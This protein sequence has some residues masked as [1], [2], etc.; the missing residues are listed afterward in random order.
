MRLTA[1]LLITS[2]AITLSV[3]QAAAAL[4]PEVKAELT[5]MSRELRSVTSLLRKKEIAEAKAIVTKTEERLKELNIAKDERDRSLSALKTALQRAKTAIPVSFESGVAPIIKDKCMR[6]HGEDQQSAGLRLDSYAAMGRGGR[7]GPLLIPRNPQRSLILAR[8]MADGQARMPRGGQKLSDEEISIIGRWIAGGAAFDGEDVQA[9]IGASTMEKKPPKPK[10]KVVMA[11]GSET[12]SFRDDV[13]PTLVNVC[14]RC[15]GDNNPRG[16]FRMTTFEQLLSGGDTGNTIVPGDPDGSYIVDLVLRQDPI[17]MPAGNQTQIKRSQAQAIEKWIREGAHFDGTDPKGTL[18]SLVPTAEELASAKLA[19]MSDKEFSDRRLEQAASLWKRVSPRENATG[20]TTDNLYVYGNAPQSRLDEFGRWGEEKVAEL[21][22]KYNLPGGSSPW[23]GRLVIFVSRTRFDYEEFNTVLLDR[24]TP[25]GV[26]GHVV[27]TPNFD[28]AYIAMFDGGNSDSA[29]SL[30]AQQLLNS[31]VAQAYLGRD[32]VALPDWLQQGFG[33]MNSQTGEDSQY[34]K[35][36]PQ[37][38]GSALTTVTTPASLFDDGTFSP[39]D[40]GPVGYLL[41]RFLL[42]N[43][44]PVKLGQLIK[45]L[46]TSRNAGRAVQAT[47]GQS[48]ANL[49]QAFLSSGGR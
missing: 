26:S 16:G 31:L 48:A 9:V 36:L 40:V 35:L 23:R 45:N 43:G 19:M 29:D 28:T 3:P 44:G 49:A 20:S 15:H 33:L 4:P 17:K 5:E 38:A 12:V 7:S 47:Y 22:S 37:K 18:R 1:T 34:F 11:D 27:I 2:A 32:G 21:A 8:L 41:T 6:C 14:L 30:N 25:R 10:V 13:A 42:N 46:R 24:R 39:E